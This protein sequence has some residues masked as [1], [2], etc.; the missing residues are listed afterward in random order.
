MPAHNTMG[1]SYLGQVVLVGCGGF[2]GSVARFMLGGWVHRLVPAA[3]MP[4][5]TLVVNVLGCLAI[6]VVGGLVE[7]RQILTPGSRAFVMIGVLGGFT[8]FSTLSFET[9]ELARHGDVLKAG[10][11]VVLQVALGLAA[12]WTGF[13]LGR[14]F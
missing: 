12:A 13:V 5:G 2:M 1:D 10:A 8:T 11:N 14:Y 3:T 9:L 6:G 4:L 7:T